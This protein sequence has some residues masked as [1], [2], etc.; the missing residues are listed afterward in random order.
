MRGEVDDGL[1]FA[2]QGG[3]RAAMNTLLRA[4]LP[5]VRRTVARYAGAHGDVDDLTQLALEQ[6]VKGLPSFRGESKLETWIHRICVRAATNR[7]KMGEVLAFDDAYHA[8]TPTS[9]ADPMAYGHLVNAVDQLKPTHRSAFVLHDVEGYT[10]AE[11]ATM[12]DVPRGTVADW[13]RKA[14][15]QLQRL[16]GPRSAV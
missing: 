6:I 7:R 11:I 8:P 4:V 13:L 1:V 16:L 14:R 5:R 15:L 10:D 2:A 9:T 3:D 12:L